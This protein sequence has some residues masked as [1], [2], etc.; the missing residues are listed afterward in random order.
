MK[1]VLCFPVTIK[2]YLLRFDT[3]EKNTLPLINLAEIKKINFLK[4]DAI[5]LVDYNKGTLKQENIELISQKCATHNIPLFVDSKKKNLSP[6]NNSIIKINNKEESAIEKLPNNYELIVTH[7]EKGAMY[8]N[9]IYKSKPVEV[10]DVCGAGDTFFSALIYKHLIENNI[11]KSIKF[12][13]KC[14]RITVSR[15]GVYALT[16][17]DLLNL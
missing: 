14:A 12:A 9:K 1:L 2:M 3:G 15:S 11:E 17:Q 5:A 8:K 7:G 16:K 13:N 10:Y 6:F 4:Y